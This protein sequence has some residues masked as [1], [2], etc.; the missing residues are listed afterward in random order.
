MPP[1]SAARSDRWNLAAVLASLG[2]TVRPLGV[3]VLMG[4]AITLA[5]RRK[6][7]QLAVITLI[8]LGIARALRRA[9]CVGIRQPLRQLY[10]LPGGIWGHRDTRGTGGRTRG[11]TYPFGAVISSFRATLQ[12]DTRWHRIIYSGI[13]PLLALVGTIAAW[14]P[15]NRKSFWPKYQPEVLFATIYVLFL[16]SY[17]YD[18]IFWLFP[19]FV[20]PVLPLLVFSCAIGFRTTAVCL[21]GSTAR[22]SDVVRPACALRECLRFQAPVRLRPSTHRKSFGRRW[23][24]HGIL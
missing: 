14:G 20:I 6:Y 12:T 1:F 5:V 18:E 8:G 17:N 9:H 15:R 7:R 2:T 22:G 19:R 21:G 16:L 13:W 24:G 11:C 4:L 10:S 3:F 23:N